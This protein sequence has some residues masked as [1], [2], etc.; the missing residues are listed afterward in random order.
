[1][2]IVYIAG[3]LTTGWDGS[4]RSYL[5][6]NIRNAEAYQVALANAG[7]GSFC[8]HA[9]TAFHREKGSTAP[10]GYYYALGMEFLKRAADAVLAV[11]GWE[12]SIGAK[13]EVEWATSHGLKV[14]FP[15]SP[16]EIQPIIDW[17]K[18]SHT[19]ND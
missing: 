14:F 10:E 19:K 13:Q 5:E 15:N 6:K 4:D 12:K 2:K 3:L 11:P 18:T 9:H 8:S 1:M 17:A 7:I 16:K